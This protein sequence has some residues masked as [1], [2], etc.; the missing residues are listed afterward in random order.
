[1]IRPE[2][3]SLRARPQV[4]L[5]STDLEVIERRTI[6]RVLRETD[7]NKVKASQKL[8]ITRMQLY[9]RLRKYGLEAAAAAAVYAG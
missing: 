7:G 5:D 9:N 3:L 6:A 2:N 8:G 4:P 1:M